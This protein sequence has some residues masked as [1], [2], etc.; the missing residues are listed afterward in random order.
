MGVTT[1]YVSNEPERVILTIIEESFNSLLI[2]VYQGRITPIIRRATL[3]HV[4]FPAHLRTSTCFILSSQNM[5]LHILA[6]VAMISMF[7]VTYKQFLTSL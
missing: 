4:I 3:R 7:C 2:S 6:A 5:F 1:E